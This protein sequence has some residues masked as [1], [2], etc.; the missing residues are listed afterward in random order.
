MRGPR[1]R[2]VIFH[3]AFWDSLTPKRG[4]EGGLRVI[5][6]SQ[7]GVRFL[8]QPQPVFPFPA[9][10]PEKKSPAIFEQKDRPIFDHHFVPLFAAMF[11]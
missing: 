5:E 4:R 8:L 7:L 9:D 1:D 2:L 3:P 10:D 11:R 6:G